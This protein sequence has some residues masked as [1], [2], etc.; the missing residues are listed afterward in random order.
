[1]INAVIRYSVQN[2]LVIYLV[3][4][5]GCVIGYWCLSTMQLDALPDLGETQVIIRSSWDRSADLIED[6]VTYPIVTAMLGTPHVKTVRGFSDFGASYVYVVFD[7]KTDIYWARSRTLEYLSS[8][9]SRLPDAVKTEIGPDATSLGWIYQYVVIDTA[10]QHS[11]A[12]LRSYQGLVPKLL[13]A[14]GPRSCGRG[15]RRRV[16]SSIPGQSRSW[17]YAAVWYLHQAG[18]RRRAGRQC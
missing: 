12:D 3:T 6:Q 16:Y 9:R 10:R 8:I 13:P 1:M 14:L 17:P 11:L 4:A 5:V 2:K 7:D 18:N 15:A